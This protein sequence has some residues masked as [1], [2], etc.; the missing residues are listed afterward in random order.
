[1]SSIFKADI[2]KNK[3]ALVTGASR[4]IGKYTAIELAKAGAKVVLVGRNL[5]LLQVTKNHISSL[6]KN[7]MTIKTDVSKQEEVQSLFDEVRK[8]YGYL[9][10]LVNSAGVSPHFTSFHKAPVEDWTKILNTNLI[11]TLS[12]CRYAFP[13]LCEAEEASVINIASIGGVVGLPKVAVYTA[14]KGGIVTFTKTLAIEWAPHNIRVNSI[15][16]GFVETDM[17]K[18]LTS[19]E[20]LRNY[21]T[22]KIPLG[23]LAKPEEI[24]NI[25]IF[26]ASPA[27]SYITGTCIVADGGW[28]AE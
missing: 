2:L 14:S 24:S 12:C 8:T 20:S 25:A 26:L 17:T 27:A 1:M 22:S 13:L 28:T 19:K 23:R 15:C 7:C 21:L 11:G 4:G 18:G 5:D 9:N 3:V 10:I 6:G 16:P